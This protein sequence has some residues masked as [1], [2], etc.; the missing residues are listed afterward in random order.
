MARKKLSDPAH[1]ETDQIIARMEKQIDREYRKAHKEV[2]E[3]LDDYLKKFAKKDEKWREWVANGTKTA[4]EYQKWATGQAFMGKRWE[5]MKDTLADD[6][7]NAHKAAEGIVNGTMPEVYAINHNYGTYL[8]EK[9]ARVNTSYTLYNR[10]T[11]ARMLRDNPKLYGRPGANVAKQ[12]RDGVLK[13]W[14]KQQIQSV[15]IQ[16][17]LQGESIPHLTERLEKVTG[18]DHAAAIR[19]A[20][21]MTTGVQSAGR[22]EA[23]VRAEKL[24]IKSKKVWVATLDE[25]TRHWH[26]ELDGVAI[27]NDEYFENEYGK[28]FEPGDP[29]ADPANIYNCRCTLNAQIEGH[30]ID[31]SDTSLRYD[32]H[33]GD[34]TYDEWKSERSSKSNPIDAQEKTG[35]AI[36]A[37]YIREYRN[38]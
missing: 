19:N 30:E 35:N 15:M 16:G 13:K 34:M 1:I 26:R 38:G 11:V 2:S 20:R 6:Y 12:I 10:D 3:K 8:V 22:R 17:I 9:G 24:G 23:F 31:Y 7:V 5:Q 14:D 18:G 25:R 33:L 21:T 29:D 4:E 36:R 37:E 32:K 28:I 27:D